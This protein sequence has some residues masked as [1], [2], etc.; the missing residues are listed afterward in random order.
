MRRFALALLALPAA[1]R[2][3][4]SAQTGGAAARCGAEAGARRTGRGRGRDRAARAGR[5]RS[6]RTRPTGCMPSRPPPRRRSRRPKRGSAPPTRSSG[7]PRPMSPRTAGSSRSEQQPVSSL[8]AGLAMMARRPPLLALADR[9]GTDELVKVRMLLDATLPVIRA[10]P[11]ASRPSSR[12]ASGSQQAALAARAELV[13][14]RDNLVAQA[15]AIRRARAD[16]RSQQALASRRPGAGRRRRRAR[17]RRR[18]RAAARRAGQQPV[19]PRASPPQLAGDDRCAAQPVRAG[20]RAAAAA[21][22]L[23][24]SGR[25]AGHRGPRRGQRQRRPL[26]R[27][28][29]CDRPRRA[30]HRARRRRRPVCRARSA[31]MTGS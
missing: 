21:V 20:R 16:A 18:R 5:G 27:P 15:A 10:G 14:S 2:R 19:D 25:R 23:P 13:R 31:T 4:R 11:R 3:A 7:S 8:L 17:R 29:A 30:G 26:A 22:R 28:D 12:R 6:A 9:G 24:A 1:A